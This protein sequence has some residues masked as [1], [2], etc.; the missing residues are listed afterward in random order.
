MKKITVHKT[1]SATDTTP[2]AWEA[3]AAGLV[4]ARYYG[5]SNCEVY[6]TQVAVF[7]YQDWRALVDRAHHEVT[8]NKLGAA[9]AVRAAATTPT[10]PL[11]SQA[12]ARQHKSIRSTDGTVDT[13]EWTSEMEPI[14]ARAMRAALNGAA[15]RIREELPNHRVETVMR[16]TD[17]V[18]VLISHPTHMPEPRRIEINAKV[19]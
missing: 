17:M 12:K 7:T 11:P 10:P 3:R 14:M 16:G 6:G 8:V 9:A 19:L 1:R 2:A 13:A 15:A 5:N 18:M 4:I